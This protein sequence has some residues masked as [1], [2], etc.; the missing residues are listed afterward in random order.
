V[1]SHG[2]M[3]Y[4]TEARYLTEHLA[5]YGYVVVSPTFPLTSF[6][7]P[8][9][10]NLSEVAGQPDD[11]R[12]LIDTF[13]EFHEDPGSPFHGLLDGSRVGSAGLSLG[14]MTTSLLTYHPVLRDPR[15]SAAVSIAGPGSMFGETF[16]RSSE[17]PLL[18]VCGD[19]D[20]MV[21]YETNALFMQ[22]MAGRKVTVATLQGASHTGFS[23]A[24]R[25]FMER[26][27]NPDAL[28][29]RALTEGRDLEADFVALL[30]GAEAGLIE[31]E[32]PLPCSLSPLPP[33]MRPSRQHE[34][35]I[36][37]ILSFFESRFAP[38]EGLR[39][40]AG[41]FLRETL[42]EENPEVAV[43]LPSVD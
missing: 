3:S 13:L 40:R 31:P 26:M 28:G 15:I 42:A 21:D 16:Y 9:G 5:S 35:T 2:F 4:G 30:G 24:A 34:L 22:E 43:L 7:A 6:F 33:A 38:S 29:C 27:D 8:G 23:Y 19:M 20:A 11:Q 39:E 12:F 10:P 36:L 41:R 25:Q 18:T 14:G 37:A 32:T 17:A 1:Y